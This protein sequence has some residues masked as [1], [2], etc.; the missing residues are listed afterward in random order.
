M[1]IGVGSGP[2]SNSIYLPLLDNFYKQ[3]GIRVKRVVYPDANVVKLFDLQNDPDEMNN[4][5]Q[6]AQYQDK[7][8]VMF[9]DLLVLQKELADP[10]D[11]TEMLQAL[12]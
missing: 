4:L 1:I 8:K 5:A 7:V 3:T 6:N 2:L 9:A 12:K 10:L 11:L